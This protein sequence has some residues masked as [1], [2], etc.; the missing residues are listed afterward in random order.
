MPAK[1]AKFRLAAGARAALYD[2]FDES[3]AKYG[4]YQA[5]AYYAGMIRI[6]GLIADF[7]GIGVNAEEFRAGYRRFRFQSHYIYYTEEQDGVA[8]RML[9]HV[10]KNPRKGFIE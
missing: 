9:L 7:P 3:N 6:F 5:E 2:I 10:R 4:R 8:I 1:Q